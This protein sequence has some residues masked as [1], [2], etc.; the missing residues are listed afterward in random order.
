MVA[1]GA[2]AHLFTGSCSDF[3]GI[4]TCEGD[5]DF[6]VTSGTKTLE[7]ASYIIDARSRSSD[8]DMTGLPGMKIIANAAP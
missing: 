1:R 5:V 2:G 7:V 4:L 3:S 6:G 8:I